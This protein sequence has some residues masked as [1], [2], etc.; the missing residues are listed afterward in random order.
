MNEAEYARRLRDRTDMHFNCCQAT[1][2]PFCESCGM[3]SEAAYAL[4]QNFGGGMGC[5]S[6]CGAVTGALMVLGM[7]G[8]TP[9]QA[10]EL[11]EYFQKMYGS[12]NCAELLRQMTE[13]KE[14]KKSHCDN[15]VEEVVVYLSER[16]HMFENR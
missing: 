2:I 1:V 14:T 6:V 12:L 16:I 4:G 13:R 15:L 8:G 7:C 3:S 5:G 11:R 9:A 10:K